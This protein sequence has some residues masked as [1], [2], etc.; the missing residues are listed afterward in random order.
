ML[1]QASSFLGELEIGTSSVTP[2]FVAISLRWRVL[3][4]SRQHSSPRARAFAMA[5]CTC[6]F[7]VMAQ[8]FLAFLP[9]LVFHLRLRPVELDAACNHHTLSET[10]R[11]N[12]QKL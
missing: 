4:F 11:L 7:A 8:P 5:C 1:T 9:R 12:P 10:Q 2:Y 6:F 3:P